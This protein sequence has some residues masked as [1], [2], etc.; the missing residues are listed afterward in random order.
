MLSP[1]TGFEHDLTRRLEH[2]MSRP[3][4][5]RLLHGFP[6]AAAMPH[7]STEVY[8]SMDS[9]PEFKLGP[10]SGKQLLVGVLPHPF[11]NPAVAGCGFCTSAQTS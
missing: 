4:R 11:C 7:A 6:L 2:F 9:R 5:H 10:D 8:S 1:T 3:Q